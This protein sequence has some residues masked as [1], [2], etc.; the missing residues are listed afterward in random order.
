MTV[1]SPLRNKYTT[2]YDGS[3]VTFNIS[4]NWTIPNPSGE[5]SLTVDVDKNLGEIVRMIQ[6]F[7]RPPII[8]GSLES[9]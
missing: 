6:V 5:F 2:T 4:D 7:G 3:H 9:P 8:G 1:S